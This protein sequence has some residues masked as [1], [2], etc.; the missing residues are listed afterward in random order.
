MLGDIG[1]LQYCLILILSSLLMLLHHNKMEN[2]LVSQMYH[3]VNERTLKKRMNKVGLMNGEMVDE[4]DNG[5]DI[6]KLN[7]CREFYH[8]KCKRSS[9]EE[10]CFCLRKSRMERLFEDG[11]N[12]LLEQMDVIKLFRELRILKTIVRM[13]IK[14][15]KQELEQVREQ[16]IMMVLD[17]QNDKENDKKLNIIE[18]H[19]TQA[20]RIFGARARKI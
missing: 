20:N 9:K 12:Q 18:I 15:T 7:Y 11:R 3:V 19:E 16:S 1:G 14:L 2:Y 8:G 6:R 17:R 13:K 4:Y 5:L 10:S